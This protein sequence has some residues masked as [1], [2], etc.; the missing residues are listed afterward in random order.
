VIFIGWMRLQFLQTG[1][2]TIEAGL[3]LVIAVT[4]VTFLLLVYKYS[5]MIDRAEKELEKEQKHVSVLNKKLHKQNRE[6]QQRNEE[7]Q[8]FAESVSH[9]IRSPLSGIRNL[10]DKLLDPAH[11]KSA[12]D[13]KEWLEL[14]KATSDSMIERT[15]RMLD[16]ATATRKSVKKAP[17]NTGFIVNE[18]VDEIK[19]ASTKVDINV[20]LKS[21][22]VVMADKAL[23]KT[24]F[25]NLIA[26]SVKY[27]KGNVSKVMISCL[28]KGRENI[29]SIKDNGIGLEM[30]NIGQLFKAFTRLPG[31][32]KHKGTGLGLSI[33]KRIVERHGGR[34]WAKPGEKGGAV[35]YFS[36]P[37]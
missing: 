24:V 8:M 31:S 1:Y 10:A 12:A 14:I 9:D 20:E 33:V 4:F 22:P 2:L 32:E 11:E 13:E 27:S 15:A 5:A 36:L 23:L 19:A 21:L 3:A 16:L 29:F 37:S 25:Y 35:F 7:L 18:V 28:R 26:N 34:V 6:L 17:V 30:K